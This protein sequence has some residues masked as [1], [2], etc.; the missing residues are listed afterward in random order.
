MSNQQNVSNQVNT[1]QQN[2]QQ[3]PVIQQPQYPCPYCQPQQE[4]TGIS[5]WTAVGIF[6]LGV[7]VGSLFS[8]PDTEEQNMQQSVKMS[9]QR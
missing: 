8:D 4:D 5:F 1:Q 3:V 9:W 7:L 6:G 2:G